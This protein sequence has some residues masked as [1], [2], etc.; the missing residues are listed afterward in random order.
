M[1]YRNLR[2]TIFFVI[3][4]LYHHNNKV[5]QDSENKVILF[6]CFYNTSSDIIRFPD[7][8]FIS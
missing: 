8:H 1:R 2:N 6:E 4:V 3:R 7:S 5:F